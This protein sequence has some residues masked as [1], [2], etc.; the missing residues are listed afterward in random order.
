MHTWRWALLF[1][2][3]LAAEDFYQL[4]GVERGATPAQLKQGYKRTIVRFHPDRFEGAEKQKMVTRFTAMQ[5]AY[6]VL[7]DAQLR[8]VYDRYGLTG[9]E[10]ARKARQQ[11]EGFAAQ[12]RAQEEQWA[13]H[14][15]VRADPLQSSQLEL[16][17][18]TSMSRFYRREQVFI[19]L[20]YSEAVPEVMA[21]LPALHK[22]ASDYH[23]VFSLARINCGE[24]EELCREF[25]VY[26]PPRL[27]LFPS[28]SGLDG[29]DLQLENFAEQLRAENSKP[30]LNNIFQRVLAAVEDYAVYLS[31]ETLQ[32]FEQSSKPKFVLFTA[33]NDTPLV[34]RVLSKEFRS[35]A[36]FGVVKPS[37]GLSTVL[38]VTNFPAIHFYLGKLVAPVVFTGKTGVDALK[39]FVRDSLAAAQKG[40]GRGSRVFA[41]AE[42]R[43]GKNC[44]AG[45]RRLC[46]LVLRE[47]ST[48]SDWERL[49][50][51]FE[52][53]FATDPVGLVM[54]AGEGPNPQLLENDA[55]VLIYKGSRGQGKL[56]TLDL[57]D[58]E[59]LIRLVS[60]CLS[61]I[62]SLPPF[63]L[64][65]LAPAPEL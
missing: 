16:L 5:E 63:A 61:S 45:D 62:I 42:V 48:P 29:R 9:L 57:S 1:A 46:V 22:A 36:D 56:F 3:L 13:A 7:S 32:R 28:H 49:T 60:D 58:T 50:E 35:P 10:E 11:Q 59:A 33:K 19:L 53:N 31:A 52:A 17:D 65:L 40:R 14:Q 23:G 37:S 38:G 43:T 51:R 34:W 25:L 15:Q 18:P 6:E 4:L 27:M 47:P 55:N 12:Q 24:E 54:L 2:S 21:A 30:F 26:A 39:T 64:P 44:A 20:F 41:S 8:N